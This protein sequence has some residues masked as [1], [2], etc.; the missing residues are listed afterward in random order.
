M[1]TYVCMRAIWSTSSLLFHSYLS[2]EFLW[3][4]LQTVW[5]CLDLKSHFN[6]FHFLRFKPNAFECLS[7]MYLLY[8]WLFDDF[9]NWLLQFFPHCKEV[10]APEWSAVAIKDCPCQ[11]NAFIFKSHDHDL[12]VVSEFEPTQSQRPLSRSHQSKNYQLST[13]LTAAGCR[14]S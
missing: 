6:F 7:V 9:S 12:K 4:W 10:A 14:I 5:K 13:L 2:K 8:L 1:F 3:Y 11:K